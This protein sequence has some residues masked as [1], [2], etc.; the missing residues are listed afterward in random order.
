MGA[1]HSTATMGEVFSQAKALVLYTDQQ[2]YTKN[3]ISEKLEREGVQVRRSADIARVA[4]LDLSVYDL[5][6][7]Q[8]DNA[9]EG[10]RRRVVDVARG[11]GK[12]CIGFAHSVTSPGWEQLRNVL[13]VRRAIMGVGPGGGPVV[14]HRPTGWAARDAAVDAD[15]S[16]P[17]PPVEDRAMGTP[18]EPEA[19]AVPP[20]P[21]VQQLTTAAEESERLAQIYADELEVERART[22]ALEDEMGKLK[23][24]VQASEPAGTS[25]EWS[26]MAAMAV[27]RTLPAT[28]GRLLEALV[29]S[30]D[31]QGAVSISRQ[32][33]TAAAKVWNT[34]YTSGL[35]ALLGAGHI[36]RSGPAMGGNVD[37]T[38]RVLAG[39]TAAARAEGDGSWAALR[40]ENDRLRS[41]LA[42]LRAQPGPAPAPAPL[43]GHTAKAR[44]IL[45]ACDA[46]VLT[47]D[48]ALAK[49]AKLLEV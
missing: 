26:G 32:R 40:S 30:A 17:P 46:D 33:L 18:P 38:Y 29:H 45:A 19:A 36:E 41:E 42:A 3:R 49:F 5:V 39:R 2:L 4:N 20:P 34:A 15:C 7:F 11:A 31:A 8:E 47:K 1:A 13:A 27:A 22:R 35:N 25:G 23:A 21:S 43:N 48:E 9:L 6:L 28:Q 14:V 16:E 44:A 37:R 12:P 24:K 10:D